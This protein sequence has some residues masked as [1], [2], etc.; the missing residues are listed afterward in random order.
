M[1]ITDLL[2]SK[3]LPKCCQTVSRNAGKITETEMEI[4]I[5]LLKSCQ[6]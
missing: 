4:E 6:K 1:E 5:E 3:C 2:L